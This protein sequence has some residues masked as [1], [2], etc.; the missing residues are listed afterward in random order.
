MATA[1]QRYALLQR[2]RN[3][4][5]E[6]AR[7]AA[8]LT[9]PGLI[10]EQ[11]AS[12]P[13]D[14]AT[15]PYSSLGARGVNN[16]AAKLLL[17]LFPPQRPFFRPEIDPQTAQQMGTKLGPAQEA[18]AGISHLAMA[19]VEASGSRPLW[20]EVFRHLIVAGNS[21]VYHPDDGTV[22]RMWRLDQYVVRRDA[23]GKLLEAVIEE[24]VYPSEL[25]EVTLAAANIK[26]DETAEP[27]HPS[28][29][30]ED[31]VKIYTM[32]LRE[33]DNIIHYQELNDVEVPG[34]RGQAKADV[35]GWQ[36]LRWQAVPGSDYGR[37]MIAEYAGDFLSLEDGWK[38]I[39]MFAAEAARII[40]I[41]D[42]NSGIDV[43]ELAQAETGDALTGFMDKI[44]TLQLEKGADFQVLWNVLQSIERRLSQ[45]FLLTANTIR[46][47]ERVTAE[48]I[49]AVAQELEDSFGGTYTVLSSEA[50]APY[51]RRVL[52]ILAKQGKAPK[53]PKTVT[54]QVVTG[55][56]ALGET[57]EAVAIMEWAK[58]LLALF[59]ENWMAANIDG[60]ELALRTGTSQG[61]MDVQGLLKSADQQAAE[62]QQ[63]L[64]AQTTA[65][66]APHLAKGAMDLAKNPEAASA[67]AEGM[68]G[69]Q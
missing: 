38:S 31:K 16:V 54:V 65:A 6:Q 7:S 39:L 5:L 50:Q 4:V 25:D 32:V 14:V 10:P 12:D 26:P 19:L 51:A 48:E 8:K 27:G 62:Q 57:H 37:S 42:P 67:I 69:S 66:V 15:Q 58:S 46:D 2:A 44:H 55:F 17:S 56:S 1:A 47:A 36:A 45:A 20:M 35:A 3:T 28:D 40:R 60:Q 24:E 34:S 33:G 53:L 29:K 49:R 13:H 61:I 22:M 9:I 68:N 52:Y 11:G 59:G 63:A 43:E 41:I 21:L 18:L 64:N 30:S 23:Q